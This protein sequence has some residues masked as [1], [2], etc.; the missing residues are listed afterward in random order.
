MFL[1]KDY[2]ALIPPVYFEMSIIA[3]QGAFYSKSFLFMIVH[4]IR[5]AMNVISSVWAMEVSW[6]SNVAALE[7]K[8]KVFFRYYFKDLEIICELHE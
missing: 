6:F 8:S 5:I 1:L 2:S 7:T 3:F 4:Y